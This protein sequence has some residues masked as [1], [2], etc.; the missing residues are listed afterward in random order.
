[1]LNSKTYGLILTLLASLLFTCTEPYELKSRNSESLLVVEATISDE[2]KTHEIK[3]SKTFELDQDEPNEI[4]NAQVWIEMSNG[5]RLDFEESQSGLYISTNLFQAQPEETYTMHIVLDD[6]NSY[7]STAETLPPTS[8]IESLERV[9]QTVDG[10]QGIQIYV[11]SS[12]DSNA[13]YFKYDFE[14]TY[15]IVVPFYN[16]LDL[17]LVNVELFGGVYYELEL[18]EKEFDVSTCY[19]TINSTDIIQTTINDSQNGAVTRFPLRFIESNNGIIRDRYSILARQQVQSLEAYNF[20]SVLN[21]LGSVDN[22]FSNTQ[23]GFIQ[24][25]IKSQV[26]VE[27]NVIGFFQ[28]TSV[29]TKRI[30]FSYNDFEMQRPPNIYDCHIE[31]EVD[32]TDNTGTDG[33]T[34][35]Y[36]FLYNALNW[37]SYNYLGGQFPTYTLVTAQCADC[38]TFS[39]T[40]IPEF[41]EE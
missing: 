20:Y 39:S 18:V 23:P 14:E 28:I 5:T 8:E 4:S 36:M 12:N 22:I 1:M 40:E 16:L 24:G 35:D 34:N 27:E 15:K 37:G 3:L 11:N 41:W 30:Y 6:G 21:E 29:S 9:L 19:T 2:L 33:D 13:V 31:V 38:T 32:Y 10:K 17:K 7:I 26:N 25:N